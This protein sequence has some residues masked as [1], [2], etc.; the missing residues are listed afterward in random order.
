MIPLDIFKE[1]I[2]P[3]APDTV[4]TDG[5]FFLCTDGIEW[6]VLNQPQGYALGRWFWDKQ[7]GCWRGHCF[8]LDFKPIVF[9]SINDLE[10]KF[11]TSQLPEYR[12]LTLPEYR[13]LMLDDT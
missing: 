10:L 1:N 4:P 2:I 8:S 7:L 12:D 3:F 13:D 5:S 6:Q 11:G 9:I